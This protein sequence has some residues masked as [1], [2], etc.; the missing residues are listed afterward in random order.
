MVVLGS[1]GRRVT[2]IAYTFLMIAKVTPV[3]VL[4]Y[5]LGISQV[6]V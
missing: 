4:L 6:H 1:G 5:T 3:P 2:V